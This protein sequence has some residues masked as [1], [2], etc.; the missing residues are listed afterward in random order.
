[1]SAR[2]WFWTPPLSPSLLVCVALLAICTIAVA[3]TNRRLRT[4]RNL[5]FITDATHTLFLSYKSEDAQ[6]VR[7][8]AEQLI[9]QGQDVWF[10]E[11]RVPLHNWD[12]DFEPE[13]RKGTRSC[14]RAVYFTNARWS[15]SAWCTQVEAGDILGR[16]P[17]GSCIEVRMP[18]ESGPHQRLPELATLPHVDA[19]GKAK[20]DILA[21]LSRRLGCNSPQ[22]P[23][24]A[25][26]ARPL[27]GH[28]NMIPYAL[29]I[30]GWS[31]AGKSRMW[32]ENLVLPTLRRTE[33]GIHL[34]V[35]VIVGKRGQ[36]RQE[37]GGS[38]DRKV[39]ENLRALAR[40]YFDHTSFGGRVRRHPSCS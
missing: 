2:I 11:Y 40:T 23:L 29:D 38:D 33:D 9:A 18:F 27:M 1:M 35:N 10:N 30:G 5:P 24:Q 26:L 21:E 22:S 16:V 12:E 20:W 3:L 32:R 31:T 19:T 34:S 4:C 36:E 39:F 25:A 13:L 15:S 17:V 28:I 14:E 7:F 6:L 37:I 8:I